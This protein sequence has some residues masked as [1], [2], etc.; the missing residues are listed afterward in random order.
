MQ[1]DGLW[2]GQ[3]CA[4]RQ[5]LRKK[6]EDEKLYDNIVLLLFYDGFYRT[7]SCCFL[8]ELLVG[9]KIKPSVLVEPA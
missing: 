6:L 5:N 2:N 4:R 8:F 3:R 7:Y 9:L 1:S